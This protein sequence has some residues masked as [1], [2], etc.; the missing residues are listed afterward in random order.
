MK[1][2]CAIVISGALLIAMVTAQVGTSGQG[3]SVKPTTSLDRV[4]LSIKRTHLKG[5]W[6]HGT[7]VD[8]STLRGFSLDQLARGGPAHFELVRDAGKFICDGEFSWGRGSGEYRFEPNPDYVAELVKMGYEAPGPDQ[9]F[10]MMLSDINLIFARNI[11]N[12]GIDATTKDLIDL[13]SHGVSFDYVHEAR[14]AGFMNLRTR[15]FIDLRNH[16]VNVAFL[17]DIKAAGYDIETRQIIDLRNHGVG[18]D[19]LRELQRAGL[20][21]EPADIVRFKNHGVNP[22]YL[23][24]LHETGYADLTAQQI[25]ELRNHGVPTKFIAEAKNLGYQFSS[26]ELIDLRNHGVDG[27]YLRK[28]RE[29]GMRNL[30]AAQITKLRQHGVE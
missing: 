3:W 8:V 24:T 2:L 27:E 23:K 16:G 25:T 26:R 4:H 30:N 12:E 1:T 11:K 14:Q 10:G 17:R 5:T 7:D 21:P 29:S 28:L 13:R 15:D 20:R 22:E 6:H 19:Y 9:L 18:S